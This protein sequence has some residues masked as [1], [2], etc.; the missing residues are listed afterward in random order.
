[1]A[2]TLRRSTAE[3][4]RQRKAEHLE[5]ALDDGVETVTGP[6]WHDVH[7]V[8]EALP[9]V[10]LDAVDLRTPLLGHT[11]DLP[12]LIAGMTGGHDGA[13]VVNGALARAA[14][15][16]GLAIGLGSQRA[17]LVDP[18][19]EPTYAVVREQAPDALVIGN[20]GAVQLIDQDDRPALTFAQ[21]RRVVEM[22][23]ADALAIHLNVLE[24]AVQPEGDRRARGVAEAIGELSATLG[25]P[26]VVKETGAGIAR[27]TAER[28]RDLGV[29]ALD[30]GGLG[31]T[32]FALVERVRARRQHDL[33]GSALGD[34]VAEWGIPTAV[35]VA[36]ARSAG[37][38][39]IATGG[40]RSGL[41]AAKALAL[42]ATAVGVA[43]PLL[44]AAREGEEAIDAWV[45]RFATT[46]ATV[47]QLTGCT[48]PAQL[49][50][51][52]HVVTGVTRAWMD[53]LGWR[54]R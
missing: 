19:L 15:R 45:L 10:D 33:R 30:V 52:P 24:E 6:G 35:S 29:A 40:V 7:L 39:L 50:R 20:I 16:H 23:G 26:I 42:G 13:T 4:M 18:T 8:H 46:L 17:A 34:D 28:L 48:T 32:S 2:A 41:D 47:L 21:L 5:V 43:R 3:T 38:P 9:E 25:V 37:L 54:A 51:R 11:L 53:D 14:Q 31:G 36:G 22:I 27:G 1:M 49:A 12:L 44:L